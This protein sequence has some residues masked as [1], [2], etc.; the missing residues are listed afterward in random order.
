MT[1]LNHRALIFLGMALTMVV[2]SVLAYWTWERLLYREA[3]HYA[4]DLSQ[5]LVHV[6]GEIDQKTDQLFTPTMYKRLNRQTLAHAHLGE[7]P[8][9]R[10]CVD[11]MKEITRNPEGG[12]GFYTECPNKNAAECYDDFLFNLPNKVFRNDYNPKSRPWYQATQKHNDW[13]V[14]EF[15]ISKKRVPGFP[16]AW[17]IGFAKHISEHPENFEEGIWLVVASPNYE[18]PQNIFLKMLYANTPPPFQQFNVSLQLIRLQQAQLAGNSQINCNAI[19]DSSGLVYTATTECQIEGQPIHYTFRKTVDHPYFLGFF[20]PVILLI[21]FGAYRYFLSVAKLQQQNMANDV[22]KAVGA[23]LVH[24]LKKGIL[25]Q[26]NKLYE[27]TE[28]PA[29][30]NHL[31]YLGL[32][33][34]YVNLLVNNFNR[35]KEKD[36]VLFTPKIYQNYLELILGQPTPTEMKSHPDW[37]RFFVPEISFYR[38]LKNIFENFNNY[39]SGTL[40]LDFKEV[41]GR[42]LLKA[43]NDI[44]ESQETCPAS[45]NLGLTI[46]RQLLEDNFGPDCRVEQEKN[47]GKFYLTL[48]FPHL[49]E[50]PV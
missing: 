1:R 39:G 33:N 20:A 31:K 22:T 43:I 34:K 24:D 3:I 19:L 21:L 15:M 5:R 2:T 36:W 9:I 28:E 12:V 6:V 13:A 11:A 23:K 49:Q 18:S 30:D 32:L 27:E 10:Q 35:Q 4:K 29:L 46:I 14:L 26:L 41:D 25:P 17:S 47:G 7:I 48:T 45:T 8:E 44:A 37:P 40:E 50:K 38:I 42:I 16:T